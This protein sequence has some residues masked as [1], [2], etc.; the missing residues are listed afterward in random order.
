[1]INEKDCAAVSELLFGYAKHLERGGD[2]AAP[3]YATLVLHL[4]ECPAC[5]G[6]LDECRRMMAA[7]RSSSAAAPAELRRNVMTKVAAEAKLKR[8]R[9]FIYAASGIAA[10]FII[11]ICIAVMQA[12]GLRFDV[13]AADKDA[14]NA[15]DG[16]YGDANVEAEDNNAGGGLGPSDDG[17][18][19]GSSD[20]KDN[21]EADKPSSPDDNVDEDF[22]YDTPITEAE[23][24]DAAYEAM[25]Q[26]YELGGYDGGVAISVSGADAKETLTI[27]AGEY[28]TAAIEGDGVLVFP[29]QMYLTVTAT[30]Q[31]LIVDFN[32]TVSAVGY[33]IDGDGERCVVIFTE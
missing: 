18:A 1:M 19:N 26:A 15:M 4:N 33:P 3:E 8:R 25:K 30:L 29:Y 13:G 22:T 21:I 12:G 20:D 24:T 17:F 6:E 10:V 32:G 27:L 9:R 31:K 23:P 7:L 14:P 2:E 11:V 5:R 16:W 28:E